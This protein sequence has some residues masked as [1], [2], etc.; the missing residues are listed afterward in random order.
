MRQELQGVDIK[1]KQTPQE[2]DLQQLVCSDQK[3][4]MRS[5]QEINTN[6]PDAVERD[7]KSEDSG[8]QLRWLEL[9]ETQHTQLEEEKDLLR[10]WS[11]W[12]ISR[13]RKVIARS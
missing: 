10:E 4:G 3:E 5:R 6:I 13:A 11:Y 7:D 12:K 9:L 1:E 8:Q 2:T